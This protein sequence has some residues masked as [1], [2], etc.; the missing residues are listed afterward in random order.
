MS[1]LNNWS[2]AE[3][4]RAPA[5][6]VAANATT[7]PAEMANRAGHKRSLRG[8]AIVA[9]VLIGLTGLLVIAFL[10]VSLGI[11][12]V[13]IAGFM[14]LIPLVVVL[15]AIRWVDR[16]EPEPRSLLAFCFLWGAITSVFVALIVGLS[17]ELVQEGLGTPI[18][19]RDWLGS[20][21]QAPVVEES[22]KGFGILIVFLAARK[23][24]DG[25]I[26]GIVYG[27]TIA[28]G[29]AFT[30]N[31]LY[32]GSEIVDS[33]SLGGVLGVFII[34]GI[35]SPFAHVMFTICTGIAIGLASRR[36]GVGFGFLALLIGLIPAMA[37]H[38]LWNAATLV[39]AD[40]FLIYYVVVQMPLFFGAVAVVFVLRRSESKMTSARLTE[41]AAAGWYS[42]GEI[43]ALA[44]AAGRRQAITWAR[45]SG[46]EQVMRR[47]IADSTRLAFIRQRMMSGHDTEQAQADEAAMLNSI[48]T[49]RA[50]L[51]G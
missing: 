41:Y 33:G 24:F 48:L 4:E 5:A 39:V 40:D 27:G 16:W 32:F 14:A 9:F 1:Q 37:L 31:I 26:D 46:R 47:Y 21:I 38:A 7:G 11:S 2:P 25:P 6:V 51:T 19:D 49:W 17:V 23:H 42:S 10:L 30:E 22:I 43:P 13:A 28:A 50:L 8:P 44:T 18:G 20:V 15:L 34:R 36:R 29:F 3:P 45:G 12:A 35:M